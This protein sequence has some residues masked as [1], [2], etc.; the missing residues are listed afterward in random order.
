MRPKEN[1]K[2]IGL[3][4][5]ITVIMIGTTFS[6]VFYGFSPA[7][8]VR[9]YDGYKFT[10]QQNG[11]VW[12]SKI[13]GKN[14]AFSFPPAD[15]EKIHVNDDI[16]PLLNGKLEI[17]S[18]YNLTSKNA[19]PIA[20]AQHQMGILLSTYDMFLRQGF[21]TNNTYNFP[22]ITCKDATANV[23]VIYFKESRNETRIYIDNNCIVAESSTDSGFLKVKDRILYEMLGVIK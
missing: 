17:D 11:G 21:T 12:S 6:F 23:P 1:K 7:P 14:V 19:Q 4:L 5:F 18:T 13:N 2:N 8:D 10:Y 16:A 22:V 3:I 9:E 15:V 20:L